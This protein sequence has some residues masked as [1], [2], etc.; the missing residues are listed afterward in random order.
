MQAF[1]Q[2]V[3]QLEVYGSKYMHLKNLVL[4]CISALKEKIQDRIN[5]ILTER[6]KSSQDSDD[7][8]KKT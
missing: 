4:F 6:V 5:I 3:E 8:I 2:T 7:K 1:L